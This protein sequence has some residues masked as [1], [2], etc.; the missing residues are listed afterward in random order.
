MTTP[1][2]T[3]KD[4]GFVPGVG[5]FVDEIGGEAEFIFAPGLEDVARAVIEK[6]DEL[7]HLKALRI[8]M[9][10]KRT[11]PMHGGK[12]TLGKCVKPGGLAKF[13]SQVHFAIW[14]AADTAETLTVQQVEAL[15]YHE[16]LHAGVDDKLQPVLWSHDVEMFTRE[17]ERY[18]LWKQDLQSAG[19]AFRQLA[20]AL[21][22]A[23]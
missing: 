18:G 20:L 1:A 2:I 6:Y 21:E 23:P 11:A 17:V 15:V 12:A 10:W 7:A 3:T 16:L 13:F 9:L 5:D 22:P 8:A 19:D 14:V 4:L